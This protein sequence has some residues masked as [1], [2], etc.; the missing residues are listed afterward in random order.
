MLG[1]IR[2]RHIDGPVPPLARHGGGAAYASDAQ[3]LEVDSAR[4]REE[5]TRR[6]RGVSGSSMPALA[7]GRRSTQGA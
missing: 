7:G 1:G 3:E 4:D 5:R 2:Q 6:G